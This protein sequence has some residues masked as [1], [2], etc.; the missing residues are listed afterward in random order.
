MRISSTNSRG[1]MKEGRKRLRMVVASGRSQHQIWRGGRG[2]TVA[3]PA[4]KWSLNV[5]INFSASLVRC[6]FSEM[7]WSLSLL[8]H[9]Y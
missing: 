5:P 8:L 7:I 6:M 3:N 9:K 4:M 1:L 2:G